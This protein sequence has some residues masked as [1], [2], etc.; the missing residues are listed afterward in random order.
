MCTLELWKCFAGHHQLCGPVAQERTGKVEPWAIRVTARYCWHVEGRERG[1]ERDASDDWVPVEADP[2]ETLKRTRGSM[3]VLDKGEDMKD[4]LFKIDAVLSK[5]S[6]PEPAKRNC[7]AH[8]L[9][10]ST[11]T[12]R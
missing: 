9:A 2:G 10:E 7:P 8:F 5:A 1:R 4:A 3:K 12:Q 11:F 6:K